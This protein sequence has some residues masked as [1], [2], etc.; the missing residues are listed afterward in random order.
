MKRDMEYI[1]E[2]LL[3][4]EAGKRVFETLSSEA[5]AILGVSLEKPVTQEEAV[6]LSGHLDLMQR[7]SLI[8]IGFSSL[9]GAVVV[10]GLTG[11]G[12]E[13]LESIRVQVKQKEQAELL[14]IKPTIWGMSIDLK[15]LARRIR[16]RWRGRE[17]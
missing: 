4:I 2:L 7:E 5:A 15:E 17:E 9:G 16:D 12:H 6:K 3:E 14:T 11:K 8:E 10:S 1:R 13:L